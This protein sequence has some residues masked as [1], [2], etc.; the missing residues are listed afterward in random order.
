MGDK[1]KQHENKRKGI[2]PLL[3]CSVAK[4]NSRKLRDKIKLIFVFFFFME[5][6]IKISKENKEGE[7]KQHILAPTHFLSRSHLKISTLGLSLL[8]NAYK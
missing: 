2:I 3:L 6:G 8:I 7:R 5:C 1:E 4:S